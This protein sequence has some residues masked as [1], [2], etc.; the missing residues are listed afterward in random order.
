MPLWPLW[1]EKWRTRLAKPIIIIIMVFYLSQSRELV[2]VFRRDAT[3]LPRFVI[4]MFGTIATLVCF[5]SV[6]PLQSPWWGCTMGA[7]TVF[8]LYLTWGGHRLWCMIT[9]AYFM[10]LLFLVRISCDMWSSHSPWWSCWQCNKENRTGNGVTR[11]YTCTH[12][13][14]RA[15]KR[16]HSKCIHLQVKEGIIIT[17]CHAKSLRV[18]FLQNGQEGFYFWCG[19]S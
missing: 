10:A 9:V 12:L 14:C 8:E 13:I 6:I 5:V 3:S 19:L 18:S 16:A 1:L 2:E 17:H 7:N 11:T 4:I 15:H